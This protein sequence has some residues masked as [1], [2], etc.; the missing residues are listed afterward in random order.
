LFYGDGD[1]NVYHAFYGFR[2]KVELD[3]TGGEPIDYEAQQAFSLLEGP[4][5]NK[6]VSM[7]RPTLLSRERVS[8]LIGVLFDYKSETVLGI[9]APLEIT[10]AFW[11]E[12]LWDSGI[13]SGG[14][15]VDQQWV[16]VGG[17]GYAAAVRIKGSAAAE[18]Y[19]IATDWIFEAGPG[20]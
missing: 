4:G 9:L 18:T 14:L 11:D 5:L 2:D 1:G 13:W 17:I 10:E 8:V 15:I 20:L 3:G 12:D 19:W 6:Y 7:M 16:T